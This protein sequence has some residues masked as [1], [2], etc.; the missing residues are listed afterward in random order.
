MP[1]VIDE[2]LVLG[3]EHLVHLGVGLEVGEEHFAT[4]L[5]NLSLVF[6]RLDHL[7]RVSSNF[8]QVAQVKV[9]S[10]DLLL[11]LDRVDLADEDYLLVTLFLNKHISL[12]LHHLLQLMLQETGREFVF[13]V[14]LVELVL[15]LFANLLLLV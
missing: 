1:S 11:V 3:H 6:L 9:Q 10:S 14:L 7:F 5:Q 2:V 13:E 15:L 4:R 8:S 12:L